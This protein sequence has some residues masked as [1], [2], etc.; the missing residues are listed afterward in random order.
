MYFYVR[1]QAVLKHIIDA[2]LAVK[3]AAKSSPSV[4][5]SHGQF[6]FSLRTVIHVVGGEGQ[7]ETEEIWATL[8]TICGGYHTE[9]N[10]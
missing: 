9:T 6:V 3:A 4:D 10:I 7:S 5:G 2:T 8:P 1:H